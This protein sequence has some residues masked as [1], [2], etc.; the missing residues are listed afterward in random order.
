MQPPIY[1]QVAAL[2][3]GADVGGFEADGVAMAEVGYGEAD[4]ASGVVG[5]G[6]VGFGAP[7]N[8]GVGLVESALARALATSACALQAN[9]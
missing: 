4:G 3:H 8:V 7:T 6:V 2:A 1:A 9:G 5:R